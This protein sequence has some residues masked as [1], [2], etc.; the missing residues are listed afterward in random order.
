MALSFD[1]VIRR[2]MLMMYMCTYTTCSVSMWRVID[3]AVMGGSALVM[4]ASSA[5]LHRGVDVTCDAF[6]AHD[7]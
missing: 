6:G 7:G 1:L 2:G 5:V 4:F 3:V